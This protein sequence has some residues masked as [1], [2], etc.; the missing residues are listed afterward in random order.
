MRAW[1]INTFI[2]APINSLSLLTTLLSL[3]NT[4]KK[5]SMKSS[6][7]IYL[8]H[9]QPKYTNINSLSKLII[10][11]KVINLQ[12]TLKNVKSQILEHKSLQEANK[13][14]NLTVL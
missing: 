11:S 14:I 9:T 7:L 1:S 12:Q 6:P 8:A 4:S 10:I 3:L 2:P 5:Y 13:T